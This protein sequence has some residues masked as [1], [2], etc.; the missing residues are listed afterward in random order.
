MVGGR[1]AAQEAGDFRIRSA[2]QKRKTGPQSEQQ[3]QAEW[4][5]TRLLSLLLLLLFHF[6]ALLLL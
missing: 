1:E 2:K 5:I 6:L 4:T 3:K